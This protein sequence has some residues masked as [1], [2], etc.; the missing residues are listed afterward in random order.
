MARVKGSSKAKR[1]F[2]RTNGV[3]RDIVR[4]ESSVDRREKKAT[5]RKGNCHRLLDSFRRLSDSCRR[6]H[7]L[8][9]VRSSDQNS[10]DFRQGTR[11]GME[12]GNMRTKKE[13]KEGR[14]RCVDRTNE[15]ETRLWHS[16]SDPRRDKRNGE[17]RAKV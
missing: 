15:T 6:R 11:E 10:P 8:M 13:I 5:K 14:N 17:V 3:V 12:K 2:H 1:T 16:F 9:S 4:V 7:R